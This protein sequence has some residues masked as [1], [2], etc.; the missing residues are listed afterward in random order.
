[1]IICKRCGIKMGDHLKP[2]IR[3]ICKDAVP[4]DPARTKAVA[5][6]A[7]T[8]IIQDRKRGSRAAN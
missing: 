4:S 1:M 2:E 3:N 6:K 8:R 7:I 5:H